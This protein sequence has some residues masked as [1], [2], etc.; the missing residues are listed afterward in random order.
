MK[1]HRG[2]F[3]TDQVNRD[4]MRCPASEL[5]RADQNHHQECFRRGVELG[6]P[7]HMQ[8]DM[9]RLVGWSRPLGLYVDSKMVRVLGL[10]EKPE[11][12]QEKDKLQERATAYWKRHHHEEVEPFRDELI[13]RVAP[14]MLDNARFLQ[15]EASVVARSGIAAELY[16]D[17]FVPGLGL[18]DKDGLADYRDLLRR[19]KQVQPGVFLDPSRDLL[20]FA[21]RFYRRS[22]S[23][24][25][26]LNAYFLQSFDA[27][28][29]ENKNLRV[30]LKLDPDIVG[31]PA[32]AR[33]LIEL[34]YWRGPLYSDDISAIP[35]GVAEHK[36][37]ERSRHYEGID[38]TQVWWKVP[39][40]RH[41]DGLAIDYRTFEVEELIENPSGGLSDDHFGCR[42]AHAEFSADE[43]AITHFDGA[44]RAYAGE[45]YLERI[46]TS[47][48][49]AGKHADYTKVFRFDGTLT[50]PHWKRLLS[51][52]FRG[53][54]LIP[55]YLGAPAEV[56][57]VLELSP[58]ENTST[59]ATVEPSLA[60]LISLGQG[61]INVPMQVCSELYLEY[62]GLHIP[63]IEVGRGAVGTYLRSRIDLSDIT[64]VGFK[65]DILNLS[66]IGFG[67]SSNLRDTLQ[68]ETTALANALHQ[69]I[70]AGLVNRAAIPLAWE[71]D[72]LLVTLTIAGKAHKVATVLQQLFT[73]IDPTQVPSEWIEPLSDLVKT[74]APTECSSV[75]WEGVKRGILAISRSGDVELQMRMPDELMQ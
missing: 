10:I 9:H 66:R 6:L 39:E 18:V 21:H 70:E 67:A 29:E 35:S 30:R 50:I 56:D 13:A 32:S 2:I 28:A 36:A 24:R 16:P 68:S 49:R 73:V 62:G 65:D 58:A 52:F 33:N 46:E 12:V 74:A 64:T 75:M 51:D 3:N 19:M 54:K 45:S 23:H 47:I 8:H 42:Y 20:L 25:N 55:E 48:N 57:D 69:D 31:H 40:Q 63:Y 61:S 27:T 7:V 22:L 14:A 44:I 37:D 53:N 15:M 72:G 5:M 60:A 71:V 1:Y 4:S 38:R 43:V 59:P 26:K 41:L 34:E 17:L 11:T